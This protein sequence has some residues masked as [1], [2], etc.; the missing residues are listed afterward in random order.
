MIVIIVLYD[1][2]KQRTL[3]HPVSAHTQKLL[4]ITQQF[5]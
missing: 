2:S 5:S 1:F 4:D 3:N